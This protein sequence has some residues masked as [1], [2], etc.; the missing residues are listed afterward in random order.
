MP[1]RMGRRASDIGLRSTEGRVIVP[2]ST[3][4]EVKMG[5]VGR[6]TVL[7]AAALF[8]NCSHEETASTR[9][10]FVELEAIMQDAGNVRQLADFAS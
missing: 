2:K 4:R 3:I 6:I 1:A 8:L 5:T 10:Y 9:E 7:D